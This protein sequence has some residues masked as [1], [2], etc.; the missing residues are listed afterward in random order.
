MVAHRMLGKA[1]LVGDLPVA[2]AFDREF[3]DLIFTFR[4]GSSTSNTS[5]F[6][7]GSLCNSITA[8]RNVR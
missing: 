3:Y 4:E 2:E 1:Q 5:H 8:N 7:S 6:E